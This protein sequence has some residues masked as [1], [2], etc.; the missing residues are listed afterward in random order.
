M[1]EHFKSIIC[2]LIQPQKG[3]GAFFA[4][5]LSEHLDR[6]HADNTD[7]GQA[8]NSAFRVSLAGSIQ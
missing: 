3:K 4:F 7:V 6:E 1:N 5:D 2:K 8:L